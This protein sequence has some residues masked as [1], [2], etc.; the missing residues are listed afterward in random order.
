MGSWREDGRDGE[1]LLRP[2]AS[3]SH[4][5]LLLMLLG[6]WIPA[7][8]AHSDSPQDGRTA[9]HVA[10][11]MN[12]VEAVCGP[13][14][15]SL[16]PIRRSSFCWTAA[17]ILPLVTIPGRLP[18]ITVLVG[19][20]DAISLFQRRMVELL[21]RF[22]SFYY[23]LGRRTSMRAT[24]TES[25]HCTWPVRRVSIVCPGLSAPSH[26]GRGHLGAAECWC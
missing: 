20:G 7:P 23:V 22:K 18:S 25:P 3:C 26:P 11:R 15:V 16:I 12:K 4:T 19:I 8:K 2:A 10:C 1:E 17:Q 6:R 9:L 5:A 21:M 24:T 13:P 14:T